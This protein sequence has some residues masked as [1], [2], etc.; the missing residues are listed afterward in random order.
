MQNRLNDCE[1]EKKLIG[2]MIQSRYYEIGNSREN[3]PRNK[4]KN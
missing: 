4:K 2:K 1:V 3:G